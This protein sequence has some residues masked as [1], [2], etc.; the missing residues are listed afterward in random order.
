MTVWASEIDIEIPAN[1]QFSAAGQSWKK[2]KEKCD[3]DNSKTCDCS[4][5]WGNNT[6][7][8]NT[9]RGDD[10]AYNND[11]PYHQHCMKAP[12]SLTSDGKYKNKFRKYR[13]DWYAAGPNGFGRVEFYVDGKHMYTATRYIPT[14]AARLV[15]G[16]W[17]GWWGGDAN[18]DTKEV[19]V[20]SINITPFKP[21]DPG[22][23]GW[24]AKNNVMYPQTY[25]QCNPDATHT[26][27]C[28]FKSLVGN[29]CEPDTCLKDNKRPNSIIPACGKSGWEGNKCR[30]R[31]RLG[32]NFQYPKDYTKNA[33]NKKKMDMAKCTCALSGKQCNIDCV[34]C[35]PNC[36]THPNCDA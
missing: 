15:F 26:Q 25:D 23:K 22:D 17:F 7:N 4:G 32:K 27:I 13:F 21:S 20:R 12:E 11:S 19:L 24:A 33:P 3:C 1:P 2:R 5:H 34:L 36:P 10:E 6:I 31:A 16:P 9:W 8:F 30:A 35:T 14:R 28:D 29:R 18:F